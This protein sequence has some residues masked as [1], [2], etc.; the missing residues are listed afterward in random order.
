[1]KNRYQGLTRG[2]S[3]RARD[4]I[5]PFLTILQLKLPAKPGVKENLGNFAAIFW[6]TS[7]V[8][9]QER[10]ETWQSDGDRET[11]ISRYL[12]KQLRYQRICECSFV[13]LVTTKNRGLSTMLGTVVS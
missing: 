11:D 3:N 6:K 10:G 1:M 9:L 2:G 8:V 13:A 7:P 4:L 12:L 5:D